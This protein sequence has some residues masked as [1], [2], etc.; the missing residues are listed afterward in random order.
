MTALMLGQ[1]PCPI[2]YNHGD[3]SPLDPKDP[4]DNDLISRAEQ[5]SNSKAIASN[6]E[7]D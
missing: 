1:I 3:Q 6:Q 4:E 2:S 7:D 5:L